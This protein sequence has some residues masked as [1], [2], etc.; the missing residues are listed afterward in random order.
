[1]CL[2]W[3]TLRLYLDFYTLLLDTWVLHKVEFAMRCYRHLYVNVNLD[4]MVQRN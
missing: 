2:N 1:M 3:I 4:L